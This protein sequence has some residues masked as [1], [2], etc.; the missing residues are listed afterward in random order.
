MNIV[1]TPKALLEGVRLTWK[2][3]LEEILTGLFDKDLWEVRI[4]ESTN[5]RSDLIFVM[6]H[7]PT[8]TIEN[9]NKIKYNIRDLYINIIFNL[10]ALEPRV[11]LYSIRGFR[12][13]MTQAEIFTRYSHSHLGNI[14]FYDINS[15]IPVKPFCFGATDLS[16]LI[17][18]LS[19][20]CT[21]DWLGIETLFI[22]LAEFVK[23]ESLEGTPH[24]YI[25]S[26]Y[27]VITERTSSEEPN[28][29]FSLIKMFGNRILGN[30]TSDKYDFTKS[31][32]S[33]PNSISF[34]EAIKLDNFPKVSGFLG[35][36]REFPDLSKI[37]ELPNSDSIELLNS[38][39]KGKPIK[40]TSTEKATFK[41]KELG[42]EIVPLDY[43]KDFKP[44]LSEVI[45]S[46]F[47]ALVQ[48]FMKYKLEYLTVKEYAR[49]KV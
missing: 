18:K 23:W 8:I 25:E 32:L 2:N 39:F 12:T 37:T 9:S 40:L 3:S 38:M 43:E 16:T 13:T 22:Q 10:D 15:T 17:G 42:L 29:E 27:D 35:V 20:N 44:L 19:L 46:A 4:K 26:V 28:Y 36:A 31:Y 33:V 14:N 30:L 24:N 49:T 5:G 6:I 11:T 45:N 7:F 21:R 34:K 41:G 1:K 48:D 47:L